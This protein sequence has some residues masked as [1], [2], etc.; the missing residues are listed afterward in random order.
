M[1]TILERETDPQPG[2][3]TYAPAGRRDPFVSLM[4]P[5]EGTAENRPHKPG[6]EGFL[7]QEVA[8]KGI[9]Q[10][11][12]GYIA[13]IQGPDGKSYFCH[14]GQR[15]FDGT[16]T[17]MDQKTVTFRQDVSDPLSPVKVRDQKKSLYPSEEARQ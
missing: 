2:Q 3:Y 14:P 5:I 8:L 16:I 12:E 15:L 17:A 10:T 9:V 1:K 13:M 11:K 6:M 7:I 4:K